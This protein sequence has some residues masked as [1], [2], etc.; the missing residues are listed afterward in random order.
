MKLW[1]KIFLGIFLTAFF[2][3]ILYG[4]FQIYENHKD[5]LRREQERSLGEMELLAAAIDNA[6]EIFGGILPGLQWY[7]KYY[8]DKGIYFSFYKKEECIYQS[9]E[10]IEP[11]IYASMLDVKNNQRKLRITKA[12]HRYYIMTAGRRNSEE[13][14]FYLRDITAVYEDRKSQ[15]WYSADFPGLRCN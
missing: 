10:G 7:G 8:E 9:L 3:V 14:L 4:C 1:H 13:V 6:E 11:E 2:V 12:D 5:N 15:T